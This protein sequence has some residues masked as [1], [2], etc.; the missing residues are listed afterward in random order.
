MDITEIRTAF[1]GDDVPKKNVAL[2]W[3][4]DEIERL[5]ADLVQVRAFAKMMDENNWRDVSL[6]IQRQGVGG[7]ST[8]DADLPTA[9][10]VRGIL[11]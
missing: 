11:K 5:R 3:A 9:A 10:D 6:R 4:Y 2:R 7:Q 8:Q 1:D